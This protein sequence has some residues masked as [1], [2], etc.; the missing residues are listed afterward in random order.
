MNLACVLHM[1]WHS[2]GSWGVGGAAGDSGLCFPSVSRTLFLRSSAPVR[3][4]KW[5]LGE[6][7]GDHHLQVP[8]MRV[9]TW[10]VGFYFSFHQYL[11]WSVC[12]G[13]KCPARLVYSQL[14]QALSSRCFALE[15][16]HRVTSTHPTVPVADI[17]V[18]GLMKVKV[19]DF[20]TKATNPG[21][22]GPKAGCRQIHFSIVSAEVTPVS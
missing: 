4:C 13:H 17:S 14:S 5:E 1:E 7:S 16:W 2:G 20:S 3:D 15:R 19:C 9:E 10:R 22:I 8:P 11:T 6:S 12:R 21:S 18:L